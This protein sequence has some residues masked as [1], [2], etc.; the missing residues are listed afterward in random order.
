M[1]ASLIPALAAAVLIAA[2]T[3]PATAALVVHEWGTFTA[4][5]DES[6][7]A[8]PG[9]NT[10]DEPVPDFVHNLAQGLLIGRH[11][12]PPAFF[13]K[14]TPRCH[15]HVTMRLET[16]VIY[17]HMPPDQAAPIELD[18]EVGFRG[19]WLSQFYP[20]AEA[21]PT[22]LRA[23]EQTW[24]GL[25]P[26]TRGTLAWRNLQVGGD[27]AGPKTDDRVWLAPRAVDAA[28][29]RTPNG[30]AERFLFYRG[31]GRLD[32]PLRVL[33]SPDAAQLIVRTQR[34]AGLDGDLTRQVNALWLADVR[35]DGRMAFRA[36]D[37]L[38]WD[39]RDG[40][41]LQT[42]LTAEFD[43][44][45]FSHD[46]RARLRDALRDA[47]IAAGLF[48][49]EADALLNTWDVSY[50][51]NP[52]LRL[53]FLVPQAWTDH[54]LPLRLSVPADV[55]RVMVGR[56]ELV[57]PKQRETLRRLAAGPAP[58]LSKVQKAFSVLG[59]TPEGRERIVRLYAGDEPI[60]S[61]GTD[62]PELYRAYLELGRFR[63]AL[64]LDAYRRE[65]T[66]PLAA[67]VKIVDLYAAPVADRPASAVDV[68]L[69]KPADHDVK[70]G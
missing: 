21:S 36:V 56:I 9:I 20:Q 29:V 26:E 68:L 37:Q 13:V 28:N 44:D 23:G 58:E 17:F 69:A 4:L 67:F 16:P 8:V 51:Q 2:P 34:P 43:A 47:I 40:M 15:P 64:V 7:G 42:P 35:P 22:Q 52:G 59:E 14:G 30:E 38:S 50:F 65:P 39:P 53:F 10:D 70:G 11:Q 3:L 61:L 19:G 33:R 66:Q 63:N 1:R 62:V 5:Q 55:T 6:G 54:V 60:T 24:S 46:N 27:G 25:S 18:V 12:V 48:P 31:V 32:A 57:Q 41:T 45:A 49:D